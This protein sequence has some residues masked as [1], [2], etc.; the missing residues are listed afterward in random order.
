MRE[1]QQMKKEEKS[2]IKDEQY[3]FTCFFF[4]M[5]I[6]SLKGEYKKR[7]ISED[8]YEELP[9]VCYFCAHIIIIIII[10]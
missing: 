10:S 4:K 9:D 6:K 7:L 1:S 2:D 5:H 3:Y 8:E